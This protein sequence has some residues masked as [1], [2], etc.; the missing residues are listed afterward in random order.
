MM[1]H[2]RSEYSISVPSFVPVHWLFFCT[3]DDAEEQEEEDDDKTTRAIP[4]Y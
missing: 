1:L 4:I 2:M 3:R